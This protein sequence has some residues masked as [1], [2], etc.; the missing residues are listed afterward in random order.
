[1]NKILLAYDI[2]KN[3]SGEFCSGFNSF[4]NGHSYYETCQYPTTD[5][6]NGW[7]TADEMAREGKV[8]FFR[9]F[10]HP[11]CTGGAFPYGG[12]WVCNT[13]GGKGIDKPWWWIRVERDGKSYC[14][15]GLDFV[16]LQE[17]DNVAFGD[18][19]EEAISEYGKVMERIT[20]EDVR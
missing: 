1:M 4:I 9:R 3:P 11:P 16:D 2:F 8:F 18:T 7:Y 5:R 12:F 17:S 14:C 6:V 20:S 15:Y 19:F 13:C 10:P